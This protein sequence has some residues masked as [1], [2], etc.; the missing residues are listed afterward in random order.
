MRSPLLALGLLV[1]LA[2]PAQGQGGVPPAEGPGLGARRD[3]FALAPGQATARLPARPVPG[4]AAVWALRD[5]AFVPLDPAAWSLGAD[6]LFRLAEAPDS[7]AVLVVAYRALPVPGPVRARLPPADSLRTLY[8]PDTSRT[9]SPTRAGPVSDAPPP[10][11]RTRGS[12]TRGVVTGSDRDASV[13]SALRLQLDGSVAPGVTLRAALTDENTPILPEGTT[14]QL[15]DL[16]RVYVE[17]EGPGVAARLG[18]VDLA[19]PGTAFAP[20]ARQVQGALVEA[21]V[22]ATGPVVDGRVVASGSAVRGVFRSQDVP[23]IEGVQG[24]YRLEGRAGEAFVVVV[25]GSERVYLDGRLMRR[26]EGADYTVDYGTGEVTFTPAHLITAERRITVDFEYTASGSTR[27]LLAAG[28]DLGLWRGGDGEARARVGVRLFREADAA[29]FSTD[30][31]LG[32]DDLQRIREAG[33]ADVLAP[34]EQRVAAFDASSPFVLYTRRDTVVAGESQ[35]IFVPATPADTLLFRVRFSRV[36]PGQGDYRRAGQARNGILYEYVGP[37]RGD[38]V[39][40]RVLPRPAARTLLDLTGE[41][42]AVPGL[43]AFGEWARSADDANTLSD[44][45]DA[46]D[47]AGAYR[48]GLRLRPL[49][50]FGGEVSGEAARLDRADGFRPLDRVRGVDFNRRWNLARAGTPFGS[51]LDSLGETVTE[52]ALRWALDETAS[53]EVEAGR[54]DLGGLRS[55]RAGLALRLGADGLTGPLGLPTLALVASLAETAGEGP[56]AEAVGTGAFRDIEVLAARPVGAFVPALAVEHERREQTGALPQDSLLAASYAFTAL[57]PGLQLALSGLDAAASVEWRRESEPLG[58]RGQEAPLADAARALTVEATA[59]AR[60]GGSVQADGR[61]AYRRKRYGD[62]FGQL[63]REDAESVAVRLSARASPAAGVDGRL[64][65]DALSERT[66]IRQE[67]YV[68]VGPDLGEFVWRDGEGEPRPGEPDGVAQVDEF[69]P[70]TTPLE[71]TYLR[72]FVPSQELVPTIGVGVGL[73][74]DLR[75]RQWGL[76]ALPVA[77]RTSVDVRE[78][79][80]ER[81]VLR[82][83]L[84]DPGLLQ[85]ADGGPDGGTV[86][87]RFRVEQEAV[88]FPDSPRAGGRLGLD[89][90]RSTAQRAAGLET[91]LTQALRAEAYGP[92]GGAVEGRIAAAAE[93]RRTE[94]EAFVSRTYDLRGLRLEPTLTWTPRP[95]LALTLAP[96][97]ASRTDALAPPTRPAGALVA[98]V[99]VEA[100]W[101]RAGRFT[102]AARAEVSEVRLRGGSGGGLALFELTEGRGPGTSA[103]WGLDAQ[104]GLTERLRAL[105]AYDGRAPSGAPVVQTLRLQLSAVF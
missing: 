34:G 62:D 52:G 45:D 30:L 16:D 57:R 100:R 9:A 11:I 103:L 42:E 40:F 72:T 95:G 35:S 26:G 54:L 39:P 91:R 97:V 83:L 101:T 76:G 22:P 90:A 80:R 99:P 18:D 53:A 48:A 73:R 41:V 13:T 47:G 71:G 1:A 3:T 84:L 25:P 23:A 55:D 37:G 63:G 69:F 27:T 87:G 81:D 5:T 105:V 20:L 15:S 14:Q 8:A 61:V 10:A 50:V 19:L 70:E 36:A 51:V 59:R 46:D 58:P 89:H 68:L 44:L 67:T 56:V 85:Q 21:R 77:L 86:N 92:L 64:V 78:E 24:P 33:D 32:P 104:V 43:V 93:R 96:V 98:R 88:F 75:P 31:G 79:T 102:L 94:S 6:G 4:S 2:A 74:L 65:Y 49:A 28:A 66:P 82:V 7:L 17:V 12:V 60:P 38:A 29:T